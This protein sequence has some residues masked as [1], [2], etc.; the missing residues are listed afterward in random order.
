MTPYAE[1]YKTGHQISLIATESTEE[2]GKKPFKVF[3]FPCSSVDSVAIITV[4]IR[5]KQYQEPVQESPDL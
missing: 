3:I 2:H 4:F 5:L 1:L